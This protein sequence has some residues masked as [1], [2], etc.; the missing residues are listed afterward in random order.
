MNMLNKIEVGQYL[1]DGI[2]KRHLEG[3]YFDI[4]PDTILL[5]IFL[6]KPII[7]EFENFNYG[8]AQFGLFQEDGVIFFLSKLGSMN[9]MDAPYNKHL[10]LEPVDNTRP[11]AGQG[12]S[13]TLVLVDA[14]DTRVEAIRVISLM[15][16]FSNLLMDAVDNQPVIPKYDL[17]LNNIYNKYPTSDDMLE[18]AIMN[19]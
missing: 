11:E 12:Y 3:P 14:F 13:V 9:W 18:E 19:N 7:E 16:T 10:A 6:E 1:N 2:P 17:V 5:M 8:K 15:N 4:L